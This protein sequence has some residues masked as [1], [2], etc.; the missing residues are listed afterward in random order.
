MR[1]TPRYTNKALSEPILL[2]GAERVLVIISSFFWIWVLAGVLPHWPSLL[3]VLG[4]VVTIYLLRLA[5]KKDPQ[6]VAIFRRN[7]RFLV[8]NRFYLARGYAGTLQKVKKVRTVPLK[9]LSRV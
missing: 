4:F 1:G 5:A 7:S 8:Q 6:G 9:L 2:M 3:I